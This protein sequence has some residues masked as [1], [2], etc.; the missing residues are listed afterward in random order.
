MSQTSWSLAVSNSSPARLL[1]YHSTIFMTYT[2]VLLLIYKWVF[3]NTCLPHS[4]SNSDGYPGEQSIPLISDRFSSNWIG[5]PWWA[6]PAKV[7]S[8]PACSPPQ[9][10][11]P[12]FAPPS[13]TFEAAKMGDDNHIVGM[14][15]LGSSR[16]IL[17]THRQPEDKIFSCGDL[18]LR[19]CWWWWWWFVVVVVEK[20]NF[21]LDCNA[22]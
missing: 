18:W 2:C 14:R 13:G 11:S 17:S 12:P 4:V 3:E 22:I 8:A 5:I 1:T 19:W 7:G 20:Y 9:K 6:Y 15:T 21:N 10:S 16:R